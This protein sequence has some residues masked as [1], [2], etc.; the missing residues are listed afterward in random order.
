MKVYEE[1]TLVYE[2]DARCIPKEDYLT[3]LSF[4]FR[5]VAGRQEGSENIF[6]EPDV[7]CTMYGEPEVLSFL[8]MAD[9]DSFKEFEGRLDRSGHNSRELNYILM[10]LHLR[11]RDL[12]HSLEM[13]GKLPFQPDWFR[14]RIAPS[15]TNTHDL[16]LLWDPWTNNE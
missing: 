9:D 11:A 1:A 5:Q 6:S 2:I 12:C 16:P 15:P 8:V 3:L 10:S 7:G 14:V 13:G 4:A